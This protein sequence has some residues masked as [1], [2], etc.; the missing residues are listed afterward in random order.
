L[1]ALI[2]ALPEALPQ[3]KAPASAD[4]SGSAGTKKKKKAPN[5]KQN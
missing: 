2:A 4:D 3:V 5:P 1:R